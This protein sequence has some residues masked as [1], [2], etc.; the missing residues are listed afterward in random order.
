[1]GKPL[2]GEFEVVDENHETGKRYDHER[3][4]EFDGFNGSDG[5]RQ[6]SSVPGSQQDIEG[7]PQE[8]AV[9][10]GGVAL[11]ISVIATPGRLGTLIIP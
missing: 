7:C 1:M 2:P 8:T 5:D 4:D 10:E 3:Y 9:V 6:S 11:H